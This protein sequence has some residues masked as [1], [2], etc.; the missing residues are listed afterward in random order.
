MNNRRTTV[1]RNRARGVAD[2]WNDR[3]TMDVVTGSRLRLSYT[4]P[5]WAVA[6][7]RYL[8]TGYSGLASCTDSSVTCRCHAWHRQNSVFMDPAAHF[9]Y[10]SCPWASGLR[11]NRHDALDPIIRK[12][13]GAAKRTC[14][15]RH[16]ITVN[17]GNVPNPAAKIMDVVIDDPHNGSSYYVD[18]HVIDPLAPSYCHIQ[19]PGVPD[20]LS[21]LQH[22]V[23][24]AI[25]LKAA[26]Y[27]REA[28]H[29][30]ALLLPFLLTTVGGFTPRSPVHDGGGL[31]D[32]KDAFKS[33]FVRGKVPV[34][35]SIGVSVEEGLL[36]SV[37]ADATGDTDNALYDQTL[38]RA[39]GAGLLFNQVVRRMS[40]AVVSGSS[41]AVLSVLRRL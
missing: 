35:G 30:G 37:A 32:P 2:F 22:T 21:S 28:N 31:L 41:D 7:R 3:T 12:L 6:V 19:R 25:K 8:G 40:H 10:N 36:R 20:S 29:R 1:E 15:S 23:R 9:H 38:T 5:Q 17:F 33:L 27:H 24:E 16:D 11:T 39:S 26:T 18:F 14:R 4:E 13:C 34:R